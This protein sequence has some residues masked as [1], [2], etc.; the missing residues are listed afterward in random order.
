MPIA[1]AVAKYAYQQAAGGGGKPHSSVT[2]WV[3]ILTGVTYD[4]DA[5]DGIPE[6]ID[7]IN[8]QP[9]TGIAEASRAIR[10]KIKHGNAHNQY[11]AMVILNALVENAGEKFQT[12]FADSHLVDA[13]KHLATDPGTDPK[14]QR[15][16]IAI[17]ASWHRS[18]GDDRSMANVA[19]LYRQVK[20]AGPPK[21]DPE[22]LRQRR[23]EELRRR[24]EEVH[25]REELERKVREDEEARKLAKIR[26]KQDKERMKAEEEERKR[27]AKAPKTTT[28]P[29]RRF[30]FE[31]EKPK[32]LEAIATAT[33]ASNNLV[34]AITLVNTDHDSLV[35]NERVQDCLNK[36]KQIRKPI[37]R[38]IQL[39]DS[40]DFVGTLIETNDRIIAALETYD[41]LS[42]PTVTEEDVESVQKA[43]GNARIGGESEVNKLQEKQR[44]AVRRAKGRRGEDLLDG[45]SAYSGA[46][47]GGSSM[48][49]DLQD[50]SFGS[51][52]AE[53]SRLPPPLRPQSGDYT[54]DENRHGSLSDYSDYQSSDEDTHNARASTSNRAYE[55]YAPRK[56]AVSEDPFAD[57]FAD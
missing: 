14:V 6:L 22:V 46:G 5:Y 11:R 3:D 19:G 28:Q 26:A 20:P 39:V 48:H 9:A 8:I 40:E 29:R 21:P 33:S 1:A 51:L 13:I 25:K 15:K 17:L 16:T 50:L 41:K 4:G 49:P 44:A 43:L 27:K 10:K 31:E 23:E 7:S 53:Q 35:T 32:V 38:Y 12:S 18:F 47:A 52:G 30:N 55:S 34:N 57:P 37:V 36:V 45:E 2:E 24:E 54:S 42:N 56:Q